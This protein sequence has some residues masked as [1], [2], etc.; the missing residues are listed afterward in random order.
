MISSIDKYTKL[1]CSFAKEAGSG[2][3][4]VHNK[5]FAIKGLNYIYKSF[6]VDDIEAAI[7]AM[8]VLGI[9]GAGVTMPYKVQAMDYLDEIDEKAREIGSINTIVNNDGHLKGFNTDYLAMRTVCSRFDTYLPV[10][11]LGRGGMAKATHCALDELG[12]CF[13][14]SITRDNWGDISGLRSSL[15]INCTPV[16]VAVYAG[17]KFI[18]CDVDSETGQEIALLQAAHQFKLYTGEEFP[19]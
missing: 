3:C 17:N 5:A 9:H 13:V 8:R 16:S 6:S 11:V 10:Y 19:C 15:I 18:N 2:G 12:F 7:S 1:C 14:S 4:R